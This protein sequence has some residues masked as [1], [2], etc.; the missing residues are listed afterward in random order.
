M[1]PLKLGGQEREMQT[2]PTRSNQCIMNTIIIERPNREHGSLRISS[3][4]ETQQTLIHLQMS[5]IYNRICFSLSFS[6]FFFLLQNNN[7]LAWHGVFI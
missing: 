5:R 7:F 6:F 1:S 2:N 4:R 3:C